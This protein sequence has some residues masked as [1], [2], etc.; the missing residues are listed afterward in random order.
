MLR[1]G[2]RRE[3]KLARVDI[4]R[5]D[6][7]HDVAAARDRGPA[8]TGGDGR[9]GDGVAIDEHDAI[10]G[11]RARR[12]NPV[13]PPPLSASVS[14]TSR[15]SRTTAAI[16]S[17]CSTV[18]RTSREGSAHSEVQRAEARTRARRGVCTDRAP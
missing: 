4:G 18:T 11:G 1:V 17:G 15:P 12:S 2:D 10:G 8:R 5:C 9:E 14:Q 16:P 7:D 13:P 6:R 3:L